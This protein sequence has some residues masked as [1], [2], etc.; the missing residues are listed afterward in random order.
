[1]RTFRLFLALSFF[2]LGSLLQAGEEAQVQEAL[3]SEKAATAI[4]EKVLAN[5]F[6]VTA[7]EADGWETKEA[8]YFAAKARADYPAAFELA[9]DCLRLRRTRPDAIVQFK[10]CDILAW[11]TDQNLYFRD[12]LKDLYAKNDLAPNLRVA[13]HDKL[14][15]MAF[16]LRDLA[17]VQ[18]FNKDDGYVRLWARIVGPFSSD[19]PFQLDVVED[20]EVNP[21]RGAY[22]D[23]FGHEVGILEDVHSTR[24]GGSLNLLEILP[25]GRQ[26]AV[27][28]VVLLA[29]PDEREAI[30][31]LTAERDRRV[32]LNSLPVYRGEQYRG[33]RLSSHQRKVKLQAGVNCLVIK[34]SNNSQP[35]LRL[36]TP[37]GG[38]APEVRAV[39]WNERGDAVHPLQPLHGFL[40]SEEMAEPGL[41][42]TETAV[43]T[44]N[45]STIAACLTRLELLEIAKEYQEIRELRA[46]LQAAWPDSSLLL[47]EDGLFQFRESQ[48]GIDSRDRL[49]KD[50]MALFKAALKFSPDT[51][52]AH[53]GLAL[54]LQDHDETEEAMKHLRLATEA[55]PDWGQALVRLAQLEKD[56][57]FDVLA[58]THL[59]AA[60]GKFGGA[61]SALAAFLMDM[62]RR[63]EAYPLF[64]QQW[65]KGALSFQKHLNL[66]MDRLV[67]SDSE[68]DW[69]KVEELIGEYE[70]IYP[71]SL[72]NPAEWR[73][74][75]AM[76]RGRIETAYNLLQSLDER[77]GEGRSYNLRLADLALRLERREEAIAWL[78]KEKNRL[79][80]LGQNDALQITR[81]LRELRGE[82]WINPEHDISLSEIDVSRYQ[83]ENFPTANQATLLKLAVHR[84]FP[85]RSA[86]S[87]SHTI[88]KV[89][90]KQG[91]TALGEL[92]VPADPDDLLYCR[93]IQPDGKV[94]EPTNIRELDFSNAASMYQVSPGCIMEYAYRSDSM[95]WRF[96]TNQQQFGF[97]AFNV[98]I[99]RARFVIIIPEEFE[100]EF[101]AKAWPR[102]FAPEVTREQGTITYLWDAQDVEPVRPEPMMSNP[103]EILRN[104]QVLLA[105]ERYGGQATNFSLPS[106]LQTDDAIAETAREV[107]QGL[108]DPREKLCAIH[109]YVR[110]ELVTVDGAVT[111]RDAMALKSASPGVARDLVRAMLTAIGIESS[112][113]N[114]NINLD[115]NQA[116]AQVRENL[117]EEFSLPLLKVELGDSEY[118]WL[119]FFSPLRHYRPGDLGQGVIGAPVLVRDD[120]GLIALERVYEY[121][122]E[123]SLLAYDSR[124]NLLPDSSAMVDCKVRFTGTA[125]GSMRSLADRPQ[126]GPRRLEQ[127]ATSLYPRIVI[128]VSDY[129]DLDSDYAGNP[130]A[131]EEPFTYEFSGNILSFCRREGDK[132]SF[133]PFPKQLQVVSSLLAPPER[134][135]PFLISGDIEL[136]QE[137]NYTAPEGWIFTEV[138]QNVWWRGEF[139]LY[140]A[141]F[142]VKGREL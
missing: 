141:N 68:E 16:S 15:E 84:I 105:P 31:E 135:I 26:G 14:L 65:E 45:A 38:I 33:Y 35:M 93:T 23:E 30:L 70:K 88:I 34:Q 21:L 74:Q 37:Q 136:H 32:W 42:L 109:A 91:I 107:T 67:A 133:T 49:Q 22:V 10:R 2:L 36:L 3:P 108:T 25:L 87:F 61:E 127:F 89:F 41:A 62:A 102:D 124:I 79:L 27:Y 138:P 129:P 122:L 53:Y 8:A 132:L 92:S 40:A 76:Q 24:R 130:Q 13:L 120:D 17:A 137:A 98:P 80:F 101:E 104:L 86:E 116:D 134:E 12:L 78:E 29:S 56:R 55:A 115:R 52:R 131:Q 19:K 58:E 90:D 96:A 99:A 43:Q 139:G 9:V 64:Q 73:I 126:E 71:E 39:S 20:F 7:A 112:L 100:G 94:F 66:L 44:I 6:S 118:E 50:G 82:K 54:Y 111:P 1:M 11:T 128:S 114:A 106:L 123:K 28:L 63:D 142:V 59:R 81:R 69:G 103:N 48:E 77:D 83:K 75:A 140:V 85:D 57:Q 125:A 5:D 121:R 110:R 18:N 95:G 51:P 60:L 119:R 113:A 47:V 4:W 97:Q 46:A 117:L 72:D